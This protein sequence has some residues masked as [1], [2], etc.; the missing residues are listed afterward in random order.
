MGLNNYIPRKEVDGVSG[1]ATREMKWHLLKT[2]FDEHGTH[3]GML[4]PGMKE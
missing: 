4:D 3:I 2:F 1:F